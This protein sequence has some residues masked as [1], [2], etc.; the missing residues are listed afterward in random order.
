[1]TTVGYELILKNR[2]RGVVLTAGTFSMTVVDP[3][4]GAASLSEGEGAAGM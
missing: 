1:M 2:R 4:S 3:A